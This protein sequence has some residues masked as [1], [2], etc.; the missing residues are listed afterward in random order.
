MTPY[1]NKLQQCL[2]DTGK[3]VEKK[4]PYGTPNMDDLQQLYDAFTEAV[5][6]GDMKAQSV[7]SG[8]LI[9]GLVKWRVE[10]M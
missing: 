10:E 1:T 7:A 5:D 8:E 9:A 6:S 4:L 2:I 3:M